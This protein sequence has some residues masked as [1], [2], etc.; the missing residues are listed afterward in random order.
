MKDSFIF[1]SIAT[2]FISYIGYWGLTQLGELPEASYDYFIFLLIYLVTLLS[3][4]AVSKIGKYDKS[5]L[6]AAIMGSIVLRLII[7]TAVNFLIIYLNRD[8][9]IANVVL[10]FVLY[11][12]FTAIETI[13]LFKKVNS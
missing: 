9:A 3:Y 4:F 11:L 10:F 7:F 12:I 6:M 13:A 1:Q 2:L 5:Y 8:E